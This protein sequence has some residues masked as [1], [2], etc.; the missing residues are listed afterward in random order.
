MRPKPN[1]TRDHQN[2]LGGRSIES[3]VC[4]EAPVKQAH[5]PRRQALTSQLRCQLATR[6]GLQVMLLLVGGTQVGCQSF[7]WWGPAAPEAPV[8]LQ[9]MPTA[10]EI[11]LAIGQNSQRIQ[12]L[13]AQVKVSVQDMPGITGKLAFERPRRLRLQAKF[14]GLPGPGV[15][16]GSNDA[17]FWVWLQTGGTGQRPVMLYANHEEFTATLSQQKTPIQPDWLIDAMGLVAIDP[18]AQLEGPIVRTDKNWEIRIRQ[19][20]PSGMM[21]RVLVVDRQHAWVIE[22]Q[23]YDE[24]GRVLGIARASDFVFYPGPDV[25]LPRRIELTI[26]PQT[27]DQM[28]LTLQMSGH[29][30]NQLSGDSE[31]L[32]LRPQPSG[33][34]AL[35]IGKPGMWMLGAAPNHN[36]SDPVSTAPNTNLPTATYTPQYRGRV[37]R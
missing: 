9:S 11:V 29:R 21:T 3:L 4:K 13:E 25:S 18:Q 17:E 28:Q 32:W 2:A 23:W 15:D 33:V 19:W 8:V 5:H 10:Q 16:L 26:A 27:Q 1:R 20:T 22:Q 7:S 31:Q 35:D 14:L 6:F 37:Y 34:Q 24:S 30:I 12:Q 36:A